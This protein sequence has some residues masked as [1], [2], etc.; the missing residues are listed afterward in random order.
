[1][2][3]ILRKS[4]L[5]GELVNQ[6]K[7]SINEELVSNDIIMT[8]GCSIFDSKATIVSKNGKNII[9]YAWY[10]RTSLVILNKLLD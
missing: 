9:L 2:N 8:T 6:I 4:S 5:S 7:Y 10:E 1:M 3:E